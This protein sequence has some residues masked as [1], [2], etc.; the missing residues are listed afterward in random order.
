MSLRARLTLL[1]ST[2]L[3]GILLLFGM[4]VYLTVSAVLF[5]QVDNTLRINAL[6]LTN[7]LG[8]ET[9]DDIST[10][11]MPSLQ[12]STR[13]SAQIWGRDRSLM[14][15]SNDIRQLLQPLDPPSLGVNTPI[16][17][18]IYDAR[19]N[20]LRV[21]SAPYKLGAR[22]QGVIQAAVNLELVDTIRNSLLYALLLLALIAMPLAA[23][24]SWLSLG[25]ALKPL[26]TATEIAEQITRADDLS[27][28]IPYEGPA[29]DEIGTLT[30][31]IN[32]SLE[33]LETLFTSQQRFLADVSHELRT[34]LTVIKGNADL[35]RKFGADDE[36]I[37]SIKDE[38]DR[39][40]R[41]VGDLLLLA[42]AESG[43]LTLSLN[44]VELDALLLEVFQEMHVL[45]GGK[46]VLKLKE[47]DEALVSGDRD[48]LKQ[49]LLNLVSN[50]I[51]YTP[52]GGEV[53]VGLARSDGQV[54]ITVRDSGPGIPTED[55]PHIFER[56]YRGE[57]SRTRSKASGFGL[58]LSI[59]YWI[60]EH[61]GGKIFVVSQAGS[62]TT[63]TVS[64]PLAA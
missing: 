23:L 58:G 14:W 33:Q 2:L 20:H 8:A 13:V 15:S 50:A 39:L 42:Q 52:Q 5:E 44:P 54:S 27:R 46:V 49:V 38:A 61:H 18:N 32:R 35:I 47:I 62:G 51:Q 53:I 40:T 60:V 41:M 59:A 56:F 57:K 6:Q 37:D 17:R 36:S 9:S 1:Y 3:G 22:P 26:E 31:A 30:G 34:P 29:D 43:K 63:F 24:A 21:L 11:N 55:L 25:Q 4:L 45:A 48:R 10:I 16:F 19:G 12:L 7:S 28:R 64:L